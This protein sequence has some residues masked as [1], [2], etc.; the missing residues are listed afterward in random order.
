M[1]TVLKC[2]LV[3]RRR[4]KAKVCICVLTDIFKLSTDLYIDTV[5]ASCSVG[6]ALCCLFGCM[7]SSKET[8]SRFSAGTGGTQSSQ[9]L[10]CAQISDSGNKSEIC[11][12]KIQTA[13]AS[14]FCFPPYC[15]AGWQL[16]QGMHHRPNALPTQTISK[17]PTSLSGRRLGLISGVRVFHCKGKCF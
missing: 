6:F 4:V 17:V 8:K 9:R 11:I 15:S 10:T 12:K 3:N 5:L 7:H 1:K 14:W 13:Q 16:V 2:Y